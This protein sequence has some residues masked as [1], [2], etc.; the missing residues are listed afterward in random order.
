MLHIISFVDVCSTLGR[1]SSTGDIQRMTFNTTRLAI[2]VTIFSRI[3]IDLFKEK[4][5]ICLIFV[6]LISRQKHLF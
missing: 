3:E 2:M 5:K 6:F 4:K 1:D